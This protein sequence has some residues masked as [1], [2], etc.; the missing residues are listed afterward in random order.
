M[1]SSTRSSR[2]MTAAR[3]PSVIG[4][5]R[6]KLICASRVVRRSP[7]GASA[8]SLHRQIRLPKGLLAS[9]EP[10]ALRRERQSPRAQ[11]PIGNRL[12]HEFHHRAS[13]RRPSRACALSGPS[14]DAAQAL[15]GLRQLEARARAPQR[16]GDAGAARRRPARA[17]ARP[18]R[19]DRRR[20]QYRARR[21]IPPRR[22]V[23]GRLG[24][25]GRRQF[26]AGQSRRLRARRNGMSGRDFRAVDVERR[27]RRGGAIGFPSCA[28]A[29]KSR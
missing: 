13:L 2:S 26:H 3:T 24:R 8:L 15:H 28:C 7:K 19:D 1:T 16:H 11:G 4:R 21:R 18:C 20:R 5:I 6:R 22:G 17:V 29:A 12:V 25:A 10:S 27:G 9:S 23:D 14:R